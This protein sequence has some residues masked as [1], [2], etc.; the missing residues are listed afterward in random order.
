MVLQVNGGGLRNDPEEQVRR[1]EPLKSREDRSSE[2]AQDE[3]RQLG[4]PRNGRVDKNMQ[5]PLNVR[6]NKEV[7]LKAD[8]LLSRRCHPSCR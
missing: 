5:V 8:C 1:A 6:K 3:S 4:P 2:M 7:K